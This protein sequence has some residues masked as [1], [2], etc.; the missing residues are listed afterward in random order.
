MAFI[1]QQEALHNVSY[2]YVLS[3]VVSL[4]EQNESIQLGRKD[5]VL[6]KRNEYVTDQ[7]NAFVEAP[8]IENILKPM[9]YTAL[10]EGMFFYSGFAF[11]YNL[12]RHNE[13]VGDRKSVV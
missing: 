2:S 9:V 11:F 5:P 13:M 12:A 8:S 1:A 10:L 7:Y 6:L 4:D 3:S